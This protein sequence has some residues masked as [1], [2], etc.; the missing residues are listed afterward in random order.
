MKKIITGLSLV[1]IST[2]SAESAF[3][4]NG[5]S[6]K[7]GTLG[8]GVE[9]STNLSENINLRFGVNGY[10]YSENDVIDNIKYDIDA[11][12][13]TATAI[14]DY[15]PFS[16]G[17]ILSG[18]AVYNGN[19]VDFKAQAVGGTF[20]ING[21]TYTASEVGSLDG[22]V[23]FNNIAPYIGLGYSTITKSKGW[24]FV[25]DAGVIYQ[26]KARSTLSVVCGSVLTAAQCT[27][28]Q[29]DVLAEKKS[30][31]D[32]LDSFKWYPVVSVGVAYRF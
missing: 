16:N 5:L 32:D 14:L 28:L 12:L 15:Y 20:D 3:S 25:A 26:G 1:V 19:K 11:K 10:N 4:N 9:Y 27:Q 7:V 24:H 30:F 23:D 6:A 21:V 13:F 22:S 18:G 8:L 31:D 2:L 17:F 29:D